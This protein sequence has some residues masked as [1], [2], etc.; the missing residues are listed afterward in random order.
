MSCSR[1][2]PELCSIGSGHVF[3]ARR[4]RAL[5]GVGPWK[6]RVGRSS[7]VRLLSVPVVSDCDWTGQ[8]ACH[9]CHWMR[10]RYELL[11]DLEPAGRGC[12]REE[13]SEQLVSR[14]SLRTTDW[15]FP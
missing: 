4:W 10:S 2:N 8:G 3:G 1:L 11:Q 14:K 7:C 9:G 5:G 13:Q 6:Q 15:R 12:V